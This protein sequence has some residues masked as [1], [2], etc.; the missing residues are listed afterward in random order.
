MLN[1]SKNINEVYCRKTSTCMRGRWLMIGY[2]SK[3]STIHN[4]LCSAWNSTVR[5]V[6]CV[7]NDIS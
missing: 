1:L 4:V 6:T 7:A 3:I 5:S 2:E